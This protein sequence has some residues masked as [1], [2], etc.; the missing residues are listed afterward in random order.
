MAGTKDPL[1]TTPIERDVVQMREVTRNRVKKSEI[2]V[3][4]MAGT[5]ATVKAPE[6]AGGIS[7]LQSEQTIH[8]V[9][10]L[11][12]RDVEQSDTLVC[13]LCGVERSRTSVR[14]QLLTRGS[15]VA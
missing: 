13:A 7:K 3:G 12:V 14:C 2:Q 15:A 1:I 11:V 9:R 4:T 8:K 10:E 5:D 6:L